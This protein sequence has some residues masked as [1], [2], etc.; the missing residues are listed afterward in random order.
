MKSCSRPLCFLT[1]G[2]KN[3]SLNLCKR[4]SDK[5]SPATARRM[6]WWHFDTVRMGA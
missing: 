4:F 2:F 5:D 1:S 6:R 3:L